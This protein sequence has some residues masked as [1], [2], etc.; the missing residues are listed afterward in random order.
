MKIS[1]AIKVNRF[2]DARL[3]ISALLTASCNP[4]PRAFPF[5]KLG[6]AGKFHKGKSPGNE[7]EL[8]YPGTFGKVGR[9]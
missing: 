2:K 5:M 9:K 6:G 4:V 3:V 8:V 1:K 7:V